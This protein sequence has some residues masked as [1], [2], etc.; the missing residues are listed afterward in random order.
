MIK[1]I[2]LAVNGVFAVAAIALLMA[3]LRYP[4]VAFIEIPTVVF[5]IFL[6]VVRE[7]FFIDFFS[8]LLS[9]SKSQKA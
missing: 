5:R 2:E 1:I 8:D 3:A 4:R 9:K 7:V 6:N